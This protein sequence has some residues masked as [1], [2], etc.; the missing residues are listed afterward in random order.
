MPERI[1]H[2]TRVTL[3]SICYGGMCTLGVDDIWDLFE[4]LAWY[5][6]HCENASESCMCDS[7]IST[8]YMLMLLSCALIVNLWTIIRILVPIMIFLMNVVRH[9]IP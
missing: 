5:Q 8:I 2:G 1:I 6:S 3:E 9:L 4:S 7:P